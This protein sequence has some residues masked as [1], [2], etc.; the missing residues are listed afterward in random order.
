MQIK[1]GIALYHHQTSTG[2]V[3]F[4]TAFAT[5]INSAMFL[6]IE[7]LSTAVLSFLSMLWCIYVTFRVGN[8][9]PKSLYKGKNDILIT[10]ISETGCNKIK[11]IGHKNRL[12]ELWDTFLWFKCWF[13]HFTT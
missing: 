13:Q 8:R 1:F 2:N 5:N 4:F 7:Q 9:I 11:T 6:T 12:N 3:F 10:S